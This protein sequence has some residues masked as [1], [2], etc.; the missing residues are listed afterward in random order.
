[1]EQ[2]RRRIWVRGRALW[3]TVWE[4]QFMQRGHKEIQGKGKPTCARFRQESVHFPGAPASSYPY[5]K[6]LYL[7]VSPVNGEIEPVSQGGF[8]DQ[9][10]YCTKNSTQHPQAAGRL[11]LLSSYCA[12]GVHSFTLPSWI[13]F[14][15]RNHFESFHYRD[16]HEMTVGQQ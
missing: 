7:S 15:P 9:M 3:A 16:K 10:S 2:R 12:L 1:M 8:M 5:S 6:F 13:F 14:F 11:L 4:A